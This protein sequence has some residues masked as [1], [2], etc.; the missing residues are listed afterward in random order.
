MDPTVR[1]WLNESGMAMFAADFDDELTVLTL[2]ASHPESNRLPKEVLHAWCRRLSEAR[3]TWRQAEVAFVH[4][5]RDAGWA[6]ERIRVAL[7]LGQN[8]DLDDH[9]SILERQSVEQH[10]SRSPGSWGAAP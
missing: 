9:V 2:V 8:Q 7:G 6:D 5:A 10:P 4:A 3:M 1:K